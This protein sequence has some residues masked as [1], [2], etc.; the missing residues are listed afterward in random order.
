MDKLDGVYKKGDKLSDI[1]DS[2]KVEESLDVKLLRDLPL[3]KPFISKMIIDYYDASESV[4]YKVLKSLVRDG[5]LEKSKGSFLKR[6][7]ITVYTRI[8]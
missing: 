1:L 5:I 4:V 6:N 2:I 3:N 8:K 7:N